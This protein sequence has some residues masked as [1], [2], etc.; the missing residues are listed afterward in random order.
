MGAEEWGIATSALI[1]QGCILMRK[2]H[3]NTCPVGIATQNGELRKIHRKCR[4]FGE[5][6]HILWQRKPEKL[7]LRF[8][9]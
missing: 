3:E 8:R 4:S 1:V 7:W 6:F 5:L 9:F 2:C